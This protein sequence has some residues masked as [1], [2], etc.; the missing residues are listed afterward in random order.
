MTDPTILRNYR[1]AIALNNMG[2]A[3]VEQRAYRQGLDTLKDAISVM[4][5]S[6]LYPLSRLP[7]SV[8][9]TTLHA[10]AKV[11]RAIKR[12][13][14]PQPVPSSLGVAVISYDGPSSYQSST[15]IVRSGETASPF[16]FPIRIEATDFES[17]KDPECDMQS[18]IMV[19]NLGVA[20][21]CMSKLA[22]SPV[23]GQEAALRIFNV[24]FSILSNSNKNVNDVAELNDEQVLRF[25]LMEAV[26]L[27]NVVQVLTDLGKDSEAHES[28]SKLVRLGSAIRQLDLRD[29]SWA[30]AA[31]C[32]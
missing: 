16:T 31:S 24:T 23:V 17:L 25:L 19:F 15:D 27:N 21:L 11:E 10:D 5:K 9:I 28:Y 3:L 13:S 14:K 2:V 29:E 32:A 18:A 1:S 8:S 22:K 26:V 20:H 30:P 7:S 4:K 12:M 6:V